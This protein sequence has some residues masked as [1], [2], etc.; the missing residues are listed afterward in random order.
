M[1]ACVVRP[2]L[3]DIGNIYLYTVIVLAGI[4]FTRRDSS[5]FWL[6]SV[7]AAFFFLAKSF[8]CDIKNADQWQLVR[9]LFWVG[10]DLL[11]LYTVYL[12]LSRVAIIKVFVKKGLLLTHL[13]MWLL[14]AIRIVDIHFINEINVRSVYG[15]G[16]A[17]LN[18]LI[19]FLVAAQC[20]GK[21]DLRGNYGNSIN[22][23]SSG[24]NSGSFMARTKNVGPIK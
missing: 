17:T 20:V 13:L 14:H 6:A 4:S 8:H 18:A 23:N 1:D 21:K 15:A 16:I 12:W 19:V 5:G 2:L 24:T 9:Y 7:T 10:L 22:H 3:F 11:Y